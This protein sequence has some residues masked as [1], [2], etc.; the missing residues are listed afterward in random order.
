MNIVVIVV[1]GYVVW[2]VGSWFVGLYVDWYG[3][4][5]VL[6]KL[7][8]VMCVGLMLI[9][10]MFGYVMI[11]MFVLVLFVVVWFLQGFSMGGEYGI[12]VI[13]LSE[14]VLLNWC[15]FYVGFL[16][17]SVV[18]GQFVVFG[19]MLVMQWIFVGMYDIECWVWWILFFVGGVLVLFV[20]YM[21]CNVVESDVFVVSW[22]CVV[23]MCVM[24][25]FV[26][27]WCELLF[28]IGIMIG[29]IVVFYMYIV[30]MQKYLVNLV[31]LYKEMVIWICM[32][33]L[34]LY[35]LLQLLF[36]FVLDCVGCWLVLL[37]FG[38]GGMLL[39]VLIFMMF[40]YVYELLVVFVLVFVG[41]VVLSGFM[42]VYMLV[43]VEL[44]LL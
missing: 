40:G 28:V 19:L 32:F 29:G 9:V 16:Q 43:K 4:K 41:F 3:C 37:W 2:L 39:L 21:C 8:F 36:G 26:V 10:V 14:I 22:V 5:V 31:G 6:M 35:M 34:L 1:V 12:S 38:F 13:Y 30:Y 15:G 42:L 11:G 25:D 44:F 20:L 17:V 24:V 33:V 7:V 18:V 23:K 27:Y